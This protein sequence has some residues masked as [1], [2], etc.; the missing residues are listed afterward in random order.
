MGYA[1]ALGLDNKE[2]A[3]AARAGLALTQQRSALPLLGSNGALVRCAA[4]S[5]MRAAVHKAK[6][7]VTPRALHVWRCCAAVL[8]Q[9]AGGALP[10]VLIAQGEEKALQSIQRLRIPR[11][12]CTRV[13]L[14]NARVAARAH[15]KDAHAGAA[16]L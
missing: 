11:Q 9:L 6:V 12:D 13:T 15:A 3:A 5:R 8:Q 1:P 2:A 7:R 10:G 14:A 16:Q 4:A